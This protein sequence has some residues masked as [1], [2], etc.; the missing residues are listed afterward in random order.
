V[1]IGDVDRQR[2]GIEQRV[3]PALRRI[4]GSIETKS[5]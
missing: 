1:R 4:G 5:L 2:A 3:R